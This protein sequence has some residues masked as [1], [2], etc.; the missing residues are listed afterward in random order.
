MA[1]I[2]DNEIPPLHARPDIDAEQMDCYC[3][4]PVYGAPTAVVSET[5]DGQDYQLFRELSSISRMDEAAPHWSHHN[6][7][8]RERMIRQLMERLRSTRMHA[9][10][11]IGL[12][13]EFIYRES[14][15]KIVKMP[16]SLYRQMLN[17]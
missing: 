12:P 17:T 4:V 15:G 11:A 14:G 1:I 2:F 10:Y 16:Q 5:R 8:V 9:E 6:T 3:L 13:E 7:V